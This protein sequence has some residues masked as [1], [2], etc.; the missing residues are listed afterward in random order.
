VLRKYLISGGKY[1][2][3]ASGTVPFEEVPDVTDRPLLT[4]EDLELLLRMR[5]A[6][7]AVYEEMT[8]SSAWDPAEITMEVEQ[9]LDST[10]AALL[11]HRIANDAKLCTAKALEVD[12]DDPD[13]VHAVFSIPR[14]LIQHIGL[15][16]GEG[17]RRL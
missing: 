15:L 11:L 4:K 16:R 12:P 3:S 17:P 8:T 14:W 13:R 10:R 7:Q 5:T 2:A 9:Q 1:G 6:L